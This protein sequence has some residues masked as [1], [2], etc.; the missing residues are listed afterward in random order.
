MLKHVLWQIIK[1]T[2]IFSSSSLSFALA[3]AAAT[4]GLLT[5]EDEPAWIEKAAEEID[6]NQ[7]KED[8]SN[9]NTGDGSCSKL[10]EAL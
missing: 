2:V 7:D 4:K 1:L 10:L 3:A 8:D 9:H 5:A 6:G